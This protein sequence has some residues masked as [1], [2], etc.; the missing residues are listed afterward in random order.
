MNVP[1][2][3]FLHQIASGVAS[4]FALAARHL[5]ELPS[6]PRRVPPLVENIEVSIT[7]NGRR[8]AETSLHPRA[9]ALP[10]RGF[11]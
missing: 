3:K 8:R 6:E 7:W 10:G 11:M 1:R 2:G 5:G 4:S 9:R